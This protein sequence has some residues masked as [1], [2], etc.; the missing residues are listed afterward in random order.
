[1]RTVQATKTFDAPQQSVWDVLYD[2]P[3]ISQW[4]SGVA[5]SFA[6]GQEF[7]VGAQ[8]HCD[9][10]PTG[11]LDE[12]LV[13]LDEP[14]RVVVSIDAAK[15]IPVKRG[16][17]EFLLEPVGPGT[18]VTVNYS[19]VPNGGPLAGIVGRVMDPQLQKGFGGFLDDLGAEAA[20]RAG[21]P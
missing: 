18:K 8:R 13:E 2:F 16:R 20:R 14:D 7:G 17:V 1:M 15:R 3:N 9:L 5:S 21:T 11:Q 19:Y 4:N 12:T 6:T 10:S